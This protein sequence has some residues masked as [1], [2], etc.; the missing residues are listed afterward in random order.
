MS[1]A[2]LASAWDAV[3]RTTLIRLIRALPDPGTGQVTVLGVDDFAKR[4]RH[5]YATILIDMDTHRP[6]DYWRTA[7]LAPLA[8]W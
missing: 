4:R 3:S 1:R 8:Q 7:R 6:V 5:S 2:R